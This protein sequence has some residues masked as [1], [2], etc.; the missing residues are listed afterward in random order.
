ML[1]LR[2]KPGEGVVLAGCVVRVLRS[3]TGKVELAIDAPQTV[4]IARTN[5]FED[6]HAIA[7]LPWLFQ[8]QRATPEGWSWINVG[9]PFT[10]SMIESFREW[11][12]GIVD[13]CDGLTFRLIDPTTN[14]VVLPCPSGHLHRGDRCTHCGGR[15]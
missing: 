7:R 11:P 4:S 10:V 6:A 1:K 14:R 3:E 13:R 15:Q 12:D 2:I 8:L 9:E 5:L